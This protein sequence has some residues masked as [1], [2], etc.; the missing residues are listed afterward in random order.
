MSF[1]RKLAL[2]FAA[3]VFAAVGLVG[4]AQAGFMGLTVRMETQY[5]TIGAICC[6]ALDALVTAGVEAPPG[7]FPSYNQQAYVDI[8]DTTIEYG[9]TG[10]TNYVSATFN[11][12]HFFDVF[13][14]IDDIVGVS[15]DAA[16]NLPGFGIGRVT[17]DAD[18]IWI[19][20]ESLAATGAHHVVLNVTFGHGR[21]P[22]PETLA[23]TGLALVMLGVAR[24]RRAG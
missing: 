4:N 17:F 9:Q 12:F 23:L 10:G 21:V 2:P 13:G 20:M 7:T 16:T 24:R 1:F 11:G 18:N 8:G 14:T 5:P 22:E 6:G 15:I 19:N 3:V